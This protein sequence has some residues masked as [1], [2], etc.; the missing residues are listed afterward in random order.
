MINSLT[1][2]VREALISF[3]RNGV[4]SVAAISTVAISLFFIGF[5]VIVALIFNTKFG[6][7]EAEANVSV[8][9]KEGIST[10]KT[11]DLQKKIKDM[12]EVESA[13]YVSKTEALKRFRE[14]MKDS[15]GLLDA[16]SGNPLPASIEVKFEDEYRTPKSV[17]LLRDKL[18]NQ[19]EIDEIIGQEVVKRLFA[20][21]SVARWI[22]VT[23]I[24]LLIFAAI[25]LI[26]NAIRLAIYAR[27]KEV[28]IMKL[29]G[30][31]NWFIRWPFMFEGLLSGFIGAT[32]AVLL[33]LIANAQLFKRVE[34]IVPFLSFS[35][36][37]QDFIY[38]VL[39]LFAIGTFIGAMG[40]VLALRRFLRI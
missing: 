4:M 30:A 11:K 20:I 6:G 22:F 23:V 18:K 15:P 9:L 5:F 1:Y 34:S 35:I 3:K 2:Y 16:L 40:S 12:K 38:V 24:I 17:D 33:L 25:T 32:V 19:S 27:R 7:L 10:E 8:Y 36:G 13:K 26:V 31:S 21:A 29:V 14:R 28:E 37:Q 39:A